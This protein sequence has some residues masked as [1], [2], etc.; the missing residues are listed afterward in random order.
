MEEHDKNDKKKKYVTDYKLTKRFKSF[1]KDNLKSVP[2]I[3]PA[4]GG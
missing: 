1:A 2:D 3:I 4:V